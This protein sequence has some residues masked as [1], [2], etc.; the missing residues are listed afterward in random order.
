MNQELI[1]RIM[2]DSMGANETNSSTGNMWLYDSGCCNHMTPLSNIFDSKQPSPTLQ[3]VST[4]D[5]T[6]LPIDFSGHVSTPQLS[7][8]QTVHVLNLSISLVLVGQLCESGLIC[9]FSPFGCVV[10][11][12]R[13][14]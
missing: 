11:D 1:E 7:L 3:S 4:A 12:P 2:T 14:K 10:Q 6:C 9:L 8:N 13:T 5:G